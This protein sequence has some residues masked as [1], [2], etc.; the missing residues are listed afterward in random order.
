MLMRREYDWGHGMLREIVLWWARQMHALLPRRLLRGGDGGDALLIAAQAL[1][2]RLTLRHGGR[3]NP[4]GQF[5]VA[6]DGLAAAV[7]ALRRLPRR[8]IL[9]LGPDSL[10][11]RSVELPL[12]AERDI[13]RVI[14]FE[15]DRLTP[16]AASE[17]VWQAAVIR[18]D[19]AQRRLM[20]RLSLVPRRAIQ[21]WLDALARA[22]LAPGWL[23]LP[24]ADGSPRRLA[25]ADHV[26]PRPSRVFGI[27]A[28]LVAALLLAVVVSPFVMQYLAGDATERAI[29][30]LQPQVKRVEALRRQQ[31]DASG[32]VLVAERGRIGNVIQ[33]LAT[34]TDILP[35]D[36]WLTEFTL[37]QGKLNIAGQSPAAARLIPALAAEPTL[38]NPAFAAPVTRSPDGRT[39][40]FVIHADLAP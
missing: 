30:A 1:H 35:D 40:L 5:G 31:A 13:D 3:E 37:H 38:R 26:A 11:E 32:D 33:V 15:M 29:A 12:A 28:G 34:V 24:A 7:R 25:L 21:P 2:L 8:V 4:L 6:G 19:H 17:V 18:R 27:A 22:G 14:G 39:D 10:L 36:T 23:E 16:F 9:Q 20:L